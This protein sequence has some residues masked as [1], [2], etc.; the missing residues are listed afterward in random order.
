MLDFP[1]AAL[2]MVLRKPDVFSNPQ[3]CRED[4]LVW[5]ADAYNLGWLQRS[6]YLRADI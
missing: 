3:F 1:L 4:G 2:V 5:Y 6:P